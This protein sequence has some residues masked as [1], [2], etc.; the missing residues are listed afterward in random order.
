MFVIWSKFSSLFSDIP[1]SEIFCLLKTKV[2]FAPIW[3]QPLDSSSLGLKTFVL[4][5]Y[6]ALIYVKS[7][8][9]LKRGLFFFL[10]QW[11]Q[12]LCSDSRI[13]S[14]TTRQWAE[15]RCFD[16]RHISDQPRAKASIDSPLLDSQRWILCFFQSV[17]ELITWVIL[18]EG[19]LLPVWP[20]S[21]FKLVVQQVWL[22]SHRSPWWWRASVLLFAQ[23]NLQGWIYRGA[24]S[25]NDSLTPC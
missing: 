17:S 16:H 23:S 14:F 25:V 11:K 7:V 1:L 8:H 12:S 10:H 4:T 21:L 19:I 18:K 9:W 6:F 20:F 24:K 15:I 2:C 5:V 3:L 13:W 22:G